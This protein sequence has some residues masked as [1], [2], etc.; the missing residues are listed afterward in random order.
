MNSGYYSNIK[1]HRNRIAKRR[2][3]GIII[4]I[5]IIL[6]GVGIVGVL[7]DNGAG[8]QERV[9]IIKENQKLRSENAQLSEENEM[10]KTQ[11]S[12]KDSYINELAGSNPD[13]LQ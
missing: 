7:T 6:A 12:E 1:S 10:L 5:A 4:I 9:D 13:T 2:I 8:Y 11:L 3:T